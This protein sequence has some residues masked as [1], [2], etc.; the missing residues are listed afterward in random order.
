[1]SEKKAT[2]EPE[3]IAESVSSIIEIRPGTT[4]APSSIFSFND[5]TS[6]D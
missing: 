4:I 5:I 1:V 3:A 2:S 6:I